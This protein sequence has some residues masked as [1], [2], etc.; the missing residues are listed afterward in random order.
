VERDRQ[1]SPPPGGSV[2][3]ALQSAAQPTIAEDAD[4]LRVSVR[5]KRDWWQR[6]FYGFWLFGWT[7]GEIAVAGVLLSKKVVTADDLFL[8]VWLMGWTFAGSVVWGLWLWQMW[9][10]REL[11]VGPTTLTLRSLVLGQSRSR[12]FDLARVRK[13][14]AVEAQQGIAFDYDRKTYKFGGSLDQA[15][16]QRLIAAI[17]QRK[18]S[19][20]PVTRPIQRHDRGPD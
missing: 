11:L 14:R 15:A 9:G 17:L 2:Q 8:I 3:P 10:R 16:Q 1:S 18:P 19:A 13:L 7:I 12:A 4:G 6:L 5:V 20:K